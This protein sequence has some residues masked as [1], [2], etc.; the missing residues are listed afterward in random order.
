LAA[1]WDLMLAA[2]AVVG[3]DDIHEMNGIKTTLAVLINGV[4]LVA[5][6]VSG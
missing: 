4:A 5:F 6:V 3:L 2:L 1:A